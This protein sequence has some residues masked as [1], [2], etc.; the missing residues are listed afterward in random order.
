MSSLRSLSRLLLCVFVVMCGCGAETYRARLKE[1]AA[2]FRYQ[3]SL[4]EELGP[5]WSERGVSFQ[6]PKQFQMIPPPAPPETDEGEPAALDAA[7]DPRQ[8]HY[9]GIELPG[10]LGAWE[11]T[12]QA[13]VGGT[14]A[15][16]KA[17]L[18]VLGNHDRYLEGPD[19]EG[20]ADDPQSFLIDVENLLTDA[21]DAPALG[22]LCCGR[23]RGDGTDQPAR[24]G[25]ACAEYTG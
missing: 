24:H 15:P 10:L 9:L 16:R 3:Q 7:E 19:S 6:P 12:V 18:Y 13:D 8:P 5:K 4:N 22:L 1:T 23:R 20:F 14:E 2:Y 21:Q 17:Y 11:A 25:R